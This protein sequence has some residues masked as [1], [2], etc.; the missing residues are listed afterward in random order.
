MSNT[1]KKPPIN[2]AWTGA[3]GLVY[4]VRLI[5]VLLNAGRDVNL[6]FSSAVEQTAPI[7]LNLAVEGA[8]G[9]GHLLERRFLVGSG[10]IDDGIDAHVHAVDA[11]R[12][13][14]RVAGSAVVQATGDHQH[15][16]AQAHQ[17]SQLNTRH[18][19]LKCPCAERRAPG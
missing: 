5:D 15:D 10:H 2:V 1:V 17:Q 18:I 3:S 16:D 14:G 8:Q 13:G 12:I 19:H 4:G 6:V 7:E 11:I 9:L